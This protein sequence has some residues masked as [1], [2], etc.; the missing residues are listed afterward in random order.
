MIERTHSAFNHQST[1]VEAVM[2]RRVVVSGRVQG[3]WYRDS[4]RN[5][6][7][8][9]HVRGWVANRGDGAVEAELEG[10]SGAVEAL[11]AWMRVGPPRAVVTGVK[12]TEV[13]GTG[14]WAG[15]RVLSRPPP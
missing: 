1:A 14:D 4:C 8:I 7:E 6:A 11:I 3:V 9:L 15:F 5:Q 12:V 13:E 10:A 2:R